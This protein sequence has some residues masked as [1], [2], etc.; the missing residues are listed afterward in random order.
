MAACDALL[1]S[2]IGSRIQ[3]VIQFH[4]ISRWW[5]REGPGGT[6]KPFPEGNPRK[7]K[8]ECRFSPEA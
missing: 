4:N 2:M 6:A 3:L 5:S 8:E 1:L 7:K